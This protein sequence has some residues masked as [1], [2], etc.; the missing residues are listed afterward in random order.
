MLT[1]GTIWILTHGHRGSWPQNRFLCSQGL[2]LVNRTNRLVVHLMNHTDEHLAVHA[3]RVT[4][5]KCETTTGDKHPPCQ[6]KGK[7]HH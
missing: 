3:L 7:L 2:P 4:P 5:A 1:G 6:A